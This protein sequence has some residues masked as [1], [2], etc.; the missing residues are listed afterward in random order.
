MKKQ[1]NTKIIENIEDSHLSIQDVTIDELIP[2]NINGVVVT[3]EEEYQTI[4]LPP[5]TDGLTFKSWYRGRGGIIAKD[6]LNQK[7]KRPTGKYII[8]KGREIHCIARLVSDE[9]K[10]F[11]ETHNLIDGKLKDKCYMILK[12]LNEEINAKSKQIYINEEDIIENEPLIISGVQNGGSLEI[13]DD[14]DDYR[15]TS[16][17]LFNE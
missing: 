12:H 6:I 13:T 14:I 4:Y 5:Y 3:R 17:S 10:S 11:F 15:G 1:N 16:I 9:E 8:I 2:I 7:Y